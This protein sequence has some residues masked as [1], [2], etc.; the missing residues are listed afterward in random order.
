M[1][2]ISLSLLCTETCLKKSVMQSWKSSVM[3]R[4]NIG[5]IIILLENFQ[6]T[7]LNIMLNLSV[8]YSSLPMFGLEV[9]TSN[10]F[11][12]SSITIYPT[13]VS[14]TFIALVDLD[15]S[16]VKV[17]PSTSLRT[18]IFVFFVTLNSTTQHKLMKCQWTVKPFKYFIDFLFANII[19]FT[20]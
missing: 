8:A 9:L 4:G 3:A 12:W 19:Y 15:D 14:Y 5:W 6:I 16:A 10:R 2:P 7:N 13:T 18:T 17:S 1:K 11:H 20:W